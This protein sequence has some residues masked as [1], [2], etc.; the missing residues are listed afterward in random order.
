[1]GAANCT[2]HDKFVFTERIQFGNGSMG[3]PN[4]LGDPGGSAVITSS[5]M[6]QNYVRDSAAALPGAAQTAMQ[7]LWQVNGGGR[8]PLSDGRVVYVVETYIQSLNLGLG[9]LSSAG[10]VSARYFF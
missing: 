6:V 5:G 1:M 4:S 2:N 9:N 10:G 3:H 7:S 8:T